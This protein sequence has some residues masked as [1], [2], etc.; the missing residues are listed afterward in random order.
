MED[1]WGNVVTEDVWAYSDSECLMFLGQPLLIS[2]TE[3]LTRITPAISC[4]STSYPILLLKYCEA[5]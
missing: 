2:N 1:K 3:Y 5:T 4:L